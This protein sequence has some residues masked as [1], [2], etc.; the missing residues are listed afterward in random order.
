MRGQFK[1]IYK[2]AKLKCAKMTQR[3]QTILQHYSMQEKWLHFFFLRGGDSI[4]ELS[5]HLLHN[6]KEYLGPAWKHSAIS[7]FTQL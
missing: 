3:E 2:N 4:L 5:S 6:C 1:F 7:Y